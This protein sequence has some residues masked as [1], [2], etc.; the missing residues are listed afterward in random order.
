M[1]VLPLL[2]LLPWLALAEAPP[3]DRVRLADGLF[4]RGLHD[5]ALTEYQTLLDEYPAFEGRATLLFRAGESAR[6]LNRDERASALY[7]EAVS[8]GGDT[9]AAHRARLRLLDQAYRADEFSTARR[10]A[11]ELLALSPEPLLAASALHTLGAASLR[12]EDVEGAREA[13]TRLVASYPDDPVA[14][15]AALSLARMEP[16]GSEARREWYRAVVRNPPNPEMEV[17]GLW[18]LAR[19]E[20]DLGNTTEAANLYKRL[21]D[22]HPGRSRVRQGALHIAWAFFQDGRHGAAL[23]VAS[24]TPDERKADHLDSWLYLEAVSLRE[25]GEPD[26]AI[27]RYQRMLEETPGSRFRAPAAFDLALL[28]SQRGEHEKVLPLA[29]DLMTL[30]DRRADAFWLLAES[31][32]L[33]GEH[34]DALN[35]YQALARMEEEPERAADA[36]WQRALLIRQTNRPAAAEVFRDFARRHASDPRAGAA[37]RAAGS[38]FLER[39]ERD[40][41]ISMWAEALS[42]EPDASEAPELEY[43][44][45]LLLM[46]REDTREAIR[47]FRSVVERDPPVP[48][49]GEAAYWLGT[50]LDQTRASGAETALRLAL[51]HDLPRDKSLRA[52]FRLGAM[53]RRD[54]DDEAAFEAFL[55]LLTS[56][57]N[58]GVPDSLLVWMNLHVRDH[59]E[60]DTRRAVA[61]A[62]VKD[63]RRAETRELGH[64]ALA[65]LAAEQGRH[66][67]AARNWRAGLAFESETPESA[68]ARLRLGDALLETGANAEAAEAYGDASRLASRLNL[69]D[70]HARALLALGKTHGRMGAWEESAR[71]YLGMAVLYDDPERSPAALHAASEAFDKAGRADDAARAREELRR[72]YPETAARIL[73]EPTP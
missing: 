60:G 65:A 17:E 69:E 52:K 44:T 46:A 5:L 9:P 57:G 53:L 10:R 73:S 41:A 35:W 37:L 14:A 16:P 23:E 70:L 34:G 26:A 68:E 8:V 61:E 71:F 33:A 50:L 55:P 38:L 4:A 27:A 20:S 39:D 3:E 13:F 51:E 1:R 22:E 29:R 32:R 24:Q 64:Y 48:R 36:R 31:A 7:R 67:E 56:P 21:W 47:R 12:L 2:L 63:T 30:P 11:R 25:T 45:A 62:M 58:A 59:G 15:Y 40:T 19:L 54:G 42:K 72:R 18:G 66:A 43:Q 49:R 6:A 28:L